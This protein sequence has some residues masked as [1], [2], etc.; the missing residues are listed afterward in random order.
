VAREEISC[1][2]E[3]PEEKIALNYM[4]LLE[5]LRV[6]DTED[7]SIQFSE[8]NRA[9]SIYSNPEKDYFHIVMPMQL[10]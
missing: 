5:P 1:E 6:I 3:G 2:Y 9:I 4:Y 8:P 7:I 10:D